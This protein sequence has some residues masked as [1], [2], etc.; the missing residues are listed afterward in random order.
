M[1]YGEGAT[2]AAVAGYRPWNDSAD[3]P[4][5]LTHPSF[6][7]LRICAKGTILDL[8]ICRSRVSKGMFST[9]L[10]APMIS[11]AGSEEKSSWVLFLAI[12]SV[13]GKTVTLR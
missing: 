12:S 5:I 13:I 1:G 7:G 6:Q 2:L 10:V 8:R 9:T 4:C 3:D 11:A